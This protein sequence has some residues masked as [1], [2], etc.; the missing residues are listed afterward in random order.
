MK[1]VLDKGTRYSLSTLSDERVRHPAFRLLVDRTLDACT[2]PMALADTS[3]QQRLRAPQPLNPSL[4][5]YSTATIASPIC[6][7]VTRDSLL[8][9][10]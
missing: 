8:R 3:Q 7:V 2:D 4:P 6:I 5:T 1:T 10:W 9:P